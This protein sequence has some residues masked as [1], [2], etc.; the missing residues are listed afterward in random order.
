MSYVLDA[1]GARNIVTSPASQKADTPTTTDIIITNAH[2]NMQY[3][4]CVEC[5]LSDFRHSVCTTTTQ[6]V[7]IRTK[8]T[9]MYRSYKRFNEVMFAHELGQAPNHHTSEILEDVN[10]PYRFY[11]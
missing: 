9:L 7:P 8:R 3:T 11:E 2:K 10:D 4:I 6:N 5:D 1:Y